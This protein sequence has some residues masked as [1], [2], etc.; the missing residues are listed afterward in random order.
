MNPYDFYSL[1][2]FLEFSPLSPNYANLNNKEDLV[3]V[4]SLTKI[5]Q[6]TF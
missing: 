6:F 1:D 4:Q 3:A 2:D 5:G